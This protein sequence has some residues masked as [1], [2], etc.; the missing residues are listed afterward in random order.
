MKKRILIFSTLIL[1]FISVLSYADTTIKI[2][3]HRVNPNGPKAVMKAEIW[4]TDTKSVDTSNITLNGVAAIRTRVTPVKVIAF[5]RKADV[6][7][8]LGPVQKGQKYTLSLSF[9]AGEQPTSMT[10]D[11]TIVGKSPT[12]GNPTT[13]GR[14]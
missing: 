11:V 9:A 13:H 6:L 3:P 14:P 7:A 4:T 2:L 8:T 1:L 12:K 5:F 10:G